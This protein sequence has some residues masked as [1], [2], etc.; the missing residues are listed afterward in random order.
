MNLVY[1]QTPPLSV[2]FGWGRR[3]GVIPLWK[4]QPQDHPYHG[5]NI[6]HHVPVLETQNSITVRLEEGGAF[7]VVFLLVKVL[8]PVHLDN[9]FPARRAEVGDIRADGVL[10]AEAEASGAVSTQV[11]P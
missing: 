7:G 5:F 11:G 9:Q 10:A 1:Q 6:I 8:T 2:Y 4:N 3:E